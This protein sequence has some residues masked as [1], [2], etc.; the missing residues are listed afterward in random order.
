MKKSSFV[1]LLF[2]TISSVLFALGMCMTLLPE[3]NAFNKGVILGAIGLALGLITFIIWFKMEKKKL[4]KINRKTFLKILYI[5]LS[6]L[7]LGVGMCLCLV[8]NNFVYGI[9]IGLVGIVMLLGL[10]PMLKGLK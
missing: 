1:T 3:W 5:I 4:P 9:I 8:W 10:I 7:V 2:G 6:C